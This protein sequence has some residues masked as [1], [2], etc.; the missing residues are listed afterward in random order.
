[1]SNRFENTDLTGGH[2]F[3]FG[4]NTKIVS[5]GQCAHPDKLP[6]EV[7][8]ENPLLKHC[9]FCRGEEKCYFDGECEWKQHA[10]V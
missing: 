4:I 6:K 2:S 10:E 9:I 7:V 3:A 8:N 1:M 5:R